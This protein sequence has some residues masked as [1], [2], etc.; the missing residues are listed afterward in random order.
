MM[1]RFVKPL[2][3]GGVAAAAVLVQAALPP[4]A[5]TPAAADWPAF[6]GTNNGSAPVLPVKDLAKAKLNKLWKVET[7]TGFSS[8]AVAGTHAYTIVKRDV[9]GNPSEVLVA[10]DVRTGKEAWAAPLTIMS[11]YDGGGD[12]GT[13]DNKG[14][15]GPR[16]TPAVNDG[17]VYAIDANL[18]VYAF[19][20]A[21]GKSVWKRDV[22]KDNAGVQIK[23]QN[24]ASPVID[25]DILLMCGGGPG[26][27]LLGLNKKTGDVVW[28]GEDDKMTH[29][30]PVIADIHGVHQCI[31]FTQKGLA[32][33]DPQ[34]GTVLWRADFPYKVSTAASPVVFEDI[35]YCSAGYGVGA[36]AFKISKSG[37]AL[38]AAPLWRRE[39]ECFNHWSTPVMKDGYLYGMFSFKEYGT[40]PVACVDIRTGKDMWKQEG[41]GPGQVILSGDTVVALSDK[42]EV[43]FI[44]ADSSAYTEL[45]REDLLDG[46]VWSYPVLAYNRL[47]ARSTVE[48]GCWELK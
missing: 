1:T 26:Q 13:P 17:L 34:K 21:T 6:R 47:F 28:K 48:G 45:K 9:D 10:L 44:K 22:M 3:L 35:V 8:F 41:F 11:K 42:G 19:D 46:K 30:T 7:P 20:A 23:W 39:N 32:G 40:G 15:D 12:S 36:G 14:G 38:S 43:V 4:R 27:A 16:S 33:V 24:A 18:G 31:F 37:S 5:G 2:V 29:A 25:G